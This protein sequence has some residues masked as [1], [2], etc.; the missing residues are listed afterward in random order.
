MKGEIKIIGARENNL[1]DISVSIPWHSFTVV[2]GLSG[3]GK[4]SLALDTLYAEGLRRYIE[5]L[6]TYARQF[7]ERVDRPDMD[8][9]SG[10]PPAVAIESRNNVRNSRSTVGTT[11]EVYD[12]MR[13]LFAKIGRTYCPEC[14]VEVRRRSP[15]DIA[16]E[17][18]AGLDGKRALVTFPPGS[19]TLTPKE[20]MAAGF[21]RVVSD[22]E[23]IDIE[24]L[25]AIPA[26]AEV[27]QDRVV[28]GKKF[29]SRIV[30]ALEQALD[31]SRYVH[32]RIVDGETLRFSKEL[33]CTSCGRTFND[34]SPLLFSFNSPQGACPACKGFGNIL[35]LDAD[36]VV[37][38]PE[39]S[40]AQG[41]IEPLTK[42]SL[43]NEM[44]RLLR[45]AE[46]RGVYTNKPYEKLTDEDRRL[47]F[48]GGPGFSGVKGVFRH[49]EEKNYKMH[50]R[51]FLS[52]YRSPFTC[53]EC[54]G[55]R[56][57]KEALWVR[58]ADR[59][60]AEL[61]E[62]SIGELGEFF[63]NLSLTEYELA[64]S[65]EILKQIRSR[66]DFLNKVGLEYL[67]L[68]RLSRTLSGGEAQRVNLACQLGAALTETLYIMDEPSIGLHPR[69]VDRLVALIKELRDRDNT[70]VVVEHDFEMIREADNIIELGPLAG[71][72]G[73]EIVYQGSVKSLLG[74]KSDSLTKRYM[75]GESRIEAPKKR[76]KGSGK[77]LTV[78]G[79]RENNLKDITVSLPL[80]TFIC[81]SG[82][83]GS[84]KSS[85]VTDV[86][87]SALARRFDGSA[88]RVG[89]YGEITGVENISGIVMLDQAPIGRSSRS[90]PVTYIKAYDE[91]RKVMAGTW[92]AKSKGL[93]PSHFSFNVAGGRCETCEGAGVQL[94][95]MH[96][97]ADVY[98]TCEECGGKRFHKDV[99]SV[100]YRN[101]NIDDILALTVNEAINFFFEVPSLGRKL[102]V[103][104]DVGLGY[105]R[106]GQAAPTLSGGEAQR[107]KIAR[108]LSG[109]GGKDLLYILDEPT[110]GLHAEDVRKLLDVINRL[111]LAG[112][113]VL[114]VEHNVD[115]IKSADYVIDLGPEA[116]DAGGYIV[117]SGTPEEV[118]EAKSSYTGKYLKKALSA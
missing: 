25:D 109:K 92:D 63:E 88:E 7:L 3:S 87:Y 117:A 71:E 103:L 57:V 69:D 29:F 81:V 98:V 4:S 13:L 14:S 17:L 9:I 43:K 107:I 12:Y 68:A 105:I 39:K 45:F 90:N 52:K 100:R 79:V 50:V 26:G 101:K 74:K 19:S 97:L 104:Q 44:K 108:E 95:E 6:S 16:K 11:T 33:E 82:V 70:V 32:V 10:L 99:L 80:K 53:E 78:S 37:P 89:K 67:T 110:V 83:S 23:V 36:L 84:G 58:V 47:L 20:L 96:F 5:C 42:P 113:T 18:V 46:E 1:K 54:G 111:V 24:G 34:P 93:T 49:L 116:G 60:I 22:G 59:N 73:G 102:K 48:E 31:E 118:A 41:A 55:S 8:D 76:R 91:I 64:V 106:L 21:T 114:V 86:L 77:S 112:N 40:L 28:L 30:E 85:L 66:V 35:G 94:I 75:T 115:V 72:R 27:L 56:L 51:V 2:T 15:E 61:S 65:T 62:L 38:N